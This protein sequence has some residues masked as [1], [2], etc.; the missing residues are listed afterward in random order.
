MLQWVN[1]SPSFW[2]RLRAISTT[3]ASSWSVIRGGRPAPQ[4]GSS[5]DSPWALN[6]WITSRTVSGSAA[7]SRAIA[8]TGVPD[9]DARMINPRRYRMASA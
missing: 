1:G 7:I 5:T 3:N 2:G 9:E 6:A 8:R 4:C